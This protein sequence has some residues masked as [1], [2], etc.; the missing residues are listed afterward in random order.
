MSETNEQMSG[1]A[2]DHGHGVTEAEA[3]RANVGVLTVLFAVTAI[4]LAI[5]S[6]LLWIYFQREAEAITYQQVLAPQNPELEQLRAEEEAWLTKWGVVDREKDRYR[7][8]IA[9]GKVRF[10]EQAA[11]RRAAGQ[12]QVVVP[13][14]QPA[15]PAAGEQAGG[16]DAT[17]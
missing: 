6:Y 8:P 4:A 9:E 14:S 7:M 5:T 10:L 16:E 13:A 2:G 12:P 1:H 17:P 11:A 15:A 3:D